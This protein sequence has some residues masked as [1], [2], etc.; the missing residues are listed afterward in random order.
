MTL[1]KI[2]VL[3][4]KRHQQILDATNFH[5]ITWVLMDIALEKM[6]LLPLDTKKR[7]SN[8]MKRRIVNAGLHA[9]ILG[10]QRNARK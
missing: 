4:L 2:V 1:M 8:V 7:M 6:I 9:K 5:V 3:A 10:Q